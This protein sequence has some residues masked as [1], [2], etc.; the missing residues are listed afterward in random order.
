MTWMVCLMIMVC[1]FFIIVCTG[2]TVALVWKYIHGASN[3]FP[4][5]NFEELLIILRL[6]INSEL[7][8]YDKEIFSRKGSLTNQNFDMY[9]DDICKKVIG[10]ISPNV[11][12]QLTRYTTEE[13]VYRIVARSTKEYL[14]N[15][16]L[17]GG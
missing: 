11:M 1:A 5:D 8:E 9:Y 7:E 3:P 6:I 15:K 10:N 14:K 16:I 13:N 17:N 4:E 12:T 2:L